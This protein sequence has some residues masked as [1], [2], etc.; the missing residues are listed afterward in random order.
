MRKKKLLKNTI[1]SL[2][3]QVC[4]VVCG[5][6]LPRLI[7]NSFGSEVN[8]LVN[9]ITQ[10]LS[11]ISLLELG[12][13][14]VVQSSLY[15]PLAENNK[16]MISK[17]MTSGGLFFRRIGHILL[18]YV[19]ILMCFYPRFVHNDFEHLYTALLIAAI[20]ISSFAQYY[21]GVVDRLLLNADQRGYIQYTLQIFTLLSN[22]VISV[23]L[24]NIGCGIHIVKLAASLI[25]LSRPLFLR[26]YVNKYYC[27]DRKIKYDAEPIKQKWNGVAQHVA[28]VVLDGTDTMVL[29]V[30]SSLSDVSIYSVYHLVVYGVK[31]LLLSMTT[32]VQ[33]LL[34]ELWAKQ[35]LEEMKKAFG[36]TEWA[37]HTGSTLVFGC[38]LILIMPF[39]QVYTNG[40]TDANYIQPAFAII[41]VLANL[42]HCYRLP[43][44]VMI[45]ACGHYKQ[46]QKNY[47]IAAILNIIFSIVT[48][49]L[50][51]L[52]GVAI[53]TFVAMFYQTIWMAYYDSRNL[54]RWPFR[55][56]IKQLLIDAVTIG[57]CGAI[58][59][60]I[61]MNGINY[62]SW[63]LL[64][65]KVLAI[66]LVGMY[67]I[68][69]I[70][71]RDKIQ[72]LGNILKM[73]YKKKR[74][75]KLCLN[76]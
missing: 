63:I 23:I 21:F 13:G 20:S 42:G 30:F 54:L 28:A 65:T 67:L 32:G 34:G 12:V 8:G 53:G 9:S 59:A 46:T 3:F 71:Y 72:K 38:T 50:W 55:N 6:I 41:I 2:V 49:K 27:I 31:Q 60:L 76:Q 48:V 37:L 66:W 36:W 17:I 64:A 18:I 33:S 35:E 40:I 52:V 57:V 73:L 44:N 19:I 45:L 4:T 1:T 69:F 16:D 58:T 68:N 7:L 14:A 70:F 5:F 51:G 74:E 43:Y 11:I 10:F 15:K 56:F 26:L 25:Y 75:D 24:I 62:F 22:T 61:P 39:I 47:I 29:S